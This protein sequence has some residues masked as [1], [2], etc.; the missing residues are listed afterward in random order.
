MKLGGKLTKCGVV[1]N[2][3]EIDL[4]INPVHNTI[5]KS[6]LNNLLKWNGTNSLPDGTN[7]LREV[8]S[9]WCS[10]Q[11]GNTRTGVFNYC[12]FGD[13]TAPTS[14][15]DTELKNKISGYTSAKK[16]SSGDCGVYHVS[17]DYSFIVRITHKFSAASQNCQIKEIGWFNKV[18]P[19]GEY[20]LSS[21]VVLDYPIDINTGD[22]FYCSYEIT[23]TVDEPSI[24]SFNGIQGITHI[25]KCS[26]L[27]AK[28]SQFTNDNTDFPFPFLRTNG[29]GC[30][31]FSGTTCYGSEI[32]N[33]VWACNV[34][35]GANAQRTGRALFYL[36][37]NFLYSELNKNK[38]IWNSGNYTS[39]TFTSCFNGIKQFDV[40]NYTEDSFRRYCTVT[41]DSSWATNKL[42][43]SFIFA[44]EEFTLGTM[45]DETFVPTP[46]GKL[47][48]KEWILRFRQSWST[49]LL[50]P[51]A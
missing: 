10:N 13:G 36:D 46:Y 32:W 22:V 42:I 37:D 7:N 48:D 2:G 34:S 6:C 12:A 19:N 38:N 50:T 11:T 35:W 23:V 25:R 43:Y 28:A 1:R 40:D 49:D 29:T 26:S 51:A 44:G 47:D 16:T 31:Y 27:Y 24:Y 30:A 21:R 18:E 45:Q 9:L 20:T 39:T 3:C 5:T 4:K 41:V 17:G 14:V 15:N 33:P 8:A